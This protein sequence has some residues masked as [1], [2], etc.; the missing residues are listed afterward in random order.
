MQT[1]ADRDRLQPKRLRDPAEA[2][3][4]HLLFD[5]AKHFSLTIVD[6]DQTRH[7]VHSDLVVLVQT[8]RW[9]VTAAKLGGIGVAYEGKMTL[10]DA[11]S[12]Q[13]LVD[14][15]CVYQPVEGTSLARPLTVQSPP[16]SRKVWTVSSR[17]I[18]STMR[19]LLSWYG[20]SR[21]TCR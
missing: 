15:I 3:T 5:I 7:G 4:E 18:A 12:N 10:L 9:A 2:I 11:R 6:A 1:S 16:R 8:I 17:K 13:V 14:G 21:N 19:A 20:W